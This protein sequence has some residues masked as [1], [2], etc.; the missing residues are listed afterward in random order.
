MNCSTLQRFSA[1]RR[2]YDICNRVSRADFMEVDLFH[3]NVVNFGFGSS[4]SA[5]DIARRLLGAVAESV[6]PR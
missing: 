5:K 1:D 4:Q 3:V 2:A 6:R